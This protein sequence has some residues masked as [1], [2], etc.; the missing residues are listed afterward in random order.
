M[1]MMGTGHTAL[2]TAATA[3]ADRRVVTTDP[4]VGAFLHN[5]RRERA[6]VS[7]VY[8]C[9]DGPYLIYTV[10]DSK[11]SAALDKVY[12]AEAKTQRRFWGGQPHER[13]ALVFEHR[14]RAL[15]GQDLEDEIL[16]RGRFYQ[17]W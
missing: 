17:V 2:H 13:I 16:S 1:V 14:N 11:S 8:V 7:E 9:V 3:V 4:V 10:V 15:G 5:L 6:P 12:R